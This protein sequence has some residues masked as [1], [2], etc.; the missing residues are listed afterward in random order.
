MEEIDAV[1]LEE[2][3]SLKVL[4]VDDDP[5]INRLV[6]IRLKNRG[7][8]VSSAGDGAAAL[9]MIRS[10]SPDLVFLDVA[11]PNVGG[12]QV[13]EEI[14]RDKLD[15]AVIMMTAFGSE[16]IAVEAM[17]HGA[18]DYLP[19]PFQPV[20][21]EAVLERTVRRLLLTRQ[22]LML[23]R[24]LDLEMAQAAQVQADL[25]PQFV[26]T[27]PGFE[28]AAYFR[29][30][31]AVSGDFYDWYQDDQTLAF[32]LGDV[33]GKG[34]PAALLMATV[35]AVMRVAG[36]LRTPALALN[37]AAGVLGPDL[38]RSS[39]FV[40]LFHCQLDGA[41]R[42]FIYANAGHRLGFV[43]RADGTLE[44][45]EEQGLPLGIMSDVTYIEKSITLAAGDLVV[46]YSDGLIDAREGQEIRFND[47]AGLLSSDLDAAAVVERLVEFAVP[48]VD[49]PDDLTLL[50]LR[51]QP[52]NAL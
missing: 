49:L 25:L 30:A 17:R 52:A 36:G 8:Q 2:R 48:P 31:R 20:D 5:F 37:T 23:R 45:F 14:R 3:A 29:S 16:S 4:V 13:L 9:Q 41:N 39:R 26:P 19:K 42:Q 11:M 32:T 12:L 40:T 6:Q 27:L 44:T 10:D 24:R 34:M 7:F 18:D 50:V 1:T 47:L 21:F 46:I 22:N 35:R 43:R 28:I 33:M 38:E 15:V 51:C